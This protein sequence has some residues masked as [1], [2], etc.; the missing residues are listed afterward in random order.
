MAG[1]FTTTSLSC[2]HFAAG[3]GACMHFSFPRWRHSVHD[4]WTSRFVTK[5]RR[6]TKQRFIDIEVKF[7]DHSKRGPL[8]SW[9]I[10]HCA[11]STRVNPGL[12]NGLISFNFNNYFTFDHASKTRG[13]YFK[14]RCTTFICYSRQHLFQSEWFLPGIHYPPR[15]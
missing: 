11:A 15:L 5:P 9:G 4:N 8:T 7:S 12:V 1:P 3:G 13:H 10:H 6:C 2:R 14:L